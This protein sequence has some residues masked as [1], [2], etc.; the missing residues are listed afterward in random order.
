[1]RLLPDLMS[2][3]RPNLYNS[4]KFKPDAFSRF[5]QERE[6]IPPLT[7]ITG[8]SNEPLAEDIAARLGTVALRSVD[9]DHENHKKAP[10]AD[11][12]PNIQ[13]PQ[14]V[15]GRNVYIIQPTSPSFEDGH[16]VSDHFR[17]LIGMIQAA[18]YGSA[19]KITAVI[20][21]YGFARG[22]KK[23]LPR[24]PIPAAE[25]AREIEDVGADS[26]LIVDIHSPQFQGFVRRIPVDLLHGRVPLVQAI[27]NEGIG[28]A[29]VVSPDVGGFKRARDFYADL[30]E[31]M[32]VAAMF[33][34]RPPD[35]QD[36]TEVL[37]MIGDVEGKIALLVD[38][39]IGTAG[40]LTKAA[41]FLIKERGALEVYAAATHGVFAGDAIKRIEDSSISK[42]FVTNT[43]Q[44]REDI[45]TNLHP[46]IKEVPIADLIAEAIKRLQ[47]NQSISELLISPTTVRGNAS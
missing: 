16:S 37:G 33:K 1:M 2:G 42:V 43:I 40:S 32:G 26:M 21:Y 8:T 44:Q 19:E 11:G 28:D 18:R 25:T 31:G 13:I 9:F 35:K 23:D 14:N 30:P 47:T 39:I 3:E 15:R 5:R 4:I 29:V 24:V 22:D 34:D 45:H 41:E 38:D 12:E 10:F 46:K 27:I 36:Q 7:I 6:P 17:E 20:P